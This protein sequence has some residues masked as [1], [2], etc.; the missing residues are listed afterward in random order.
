MVNRTLRK[1][2]T[3]TSR[4]KRGG[5]WWPFCSSG[6]CINAI[7]P[8]NISR[9]KIDIKYVNYVKELTSNIVRGTPKVVEPFILREYTN[10]LV[11]LLTSIKVR[12]KYPKAP[13]LNL[14]TLDNVRGPSLG[15]PNN[16]VTRVINH[17]NTDG[18]LTSFIN[19]YA[20]RL[21]VS[22]YKYLDTND[23]RPLKSPTNTGTPLF[24]ICTS[25]INDH[26]FS[27]INTHIKDSDTTGNVKKYLEWVAKMVRVPEVPIPVPW[28]RY[29]I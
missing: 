9:I 28:T 25:V 14:R 15:R 18:S 24:D 27:M 6:S 5:G 4:K 20:S 7:E 26:L 2:Q 19:K 21:S 29:T 1:R 17:Y 16:N 8:L 23:K 11:D 22:V 3:K 13:G 10:E 12:M